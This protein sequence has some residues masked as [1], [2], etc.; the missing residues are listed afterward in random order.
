MGWCSVVRRRMANWCLIIVSH[1]ISLSGIQVYSLLVLL[2]LLRV[3]LI[4]G[5]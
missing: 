1:V 4:K 5:L 3:K 2:N